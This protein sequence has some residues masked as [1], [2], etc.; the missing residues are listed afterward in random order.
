MIPSDKSS[1]LVAIYLYICDIYK[2]ELKYECQRY[3]NNSKPE[4][5]DQEIMTIYLFTTS[6][7]NY[8]KV[9]E[10]YT[11]AKD[12]LS[13]WFPLLPSYQQFNNRLIALGNAF[14]HLSVNITEKFIPDDCDKGVSL[15]DSLPIVTC[16]GRNRKGKVAREL[17]DKGF[18]STK[19]MFYYGLKLHA[20]G[21]RRKGR[22][23]FPE[24]L[25]FTSASVNDLEGLRQGF[26]DI[27]HNRIIFADKGYCDTELDAMEKTDNLILL[28]PAKLVKGETEVTRMRDQA[29]RDLLSK[30]VST[31]RQPIESF[32]NWLNEK[33]GIQ[34]AQKV[35]STKGLLL[36]IFGRIAAAFIYLIF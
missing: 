10:I 11:F 36:H 31:V 24:R 23:P 21:F 30:A 27:L 13:S 29:Y 18:C 17:V 22:I 26:G 28:T 15:V 33:T 7:Q 8:Y 16:K 5:T 6:Q 14:Q 25:L 32:F 35:R 12:F 4:F 9:K 1:T 3:S 20:L 19:G 2:S 34:N